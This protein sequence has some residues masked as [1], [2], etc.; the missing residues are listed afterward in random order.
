MLG[1]IQVQNLSKQFHRYPVD[2]PYTFQEAILRGLRGL[3]PVERFW[4]LKEVS[5]SVEPGRMVGVLGSNGAGKSTLL[6]LIGGVGVPDEGTVITRGR[7]GALLDL[8]SGF[9]SGLDRQ[10]KCV[11]KRHHLWFDT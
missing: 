9:P 10:G 7:I 8:G 4:A 1:S 11:Y 2:R 6:R 5:F 3:R